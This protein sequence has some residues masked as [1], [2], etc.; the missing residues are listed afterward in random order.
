VTATDVTG[1]GWR[2]V[3]AV[4]LVIVA[5]LLAFLAVLAIWVNR[6]ALDTDNWTRTSS[7]LLQ[8]PVIRN[9]IA[10]RLTDQLFQ[11]VDAEAALRSVLPERAQAL[12]APA[13]NALRNQV[14]K[15][16]RKALA[17]PNVQALWADANRSAHQQLLAVLDDGGDTVS[18]RNGVVTLD[19]R[20]L[21]DRLQQEVGIGGRL[22]KVLPASA[23]QITLMRSDELRTAQ[24]G[25]RVLRPLPIFLIV[26]SLALFGAALLVAP[27]WRRR[28]LRAYGVGFVLA[29]L[30]AL[31]ARSVAGGDFVD[32]VA[33]TAAGEPAAAEVWSIATAM[34]V[35]IAVA[36]VCYGVVMI[37]G[38][39]L[40]GPTRWAV[41]ARRTVVPFWREP[42]FAY[43]A[44]ALI[45]AALVWWAPTPAWRNGPMLLILVAL[46]IAGTEALRR[47]MT[48]E[49]PGATRAE[50]A[51][52]RRER[53][54]RLTDATRRG[55]GTLRDSATR[56]AQ[57]ASG[58]VGAART[59]TVTRYGTSADDRLEQLER[60]AQLRAA[61]VLDEQELRAEKARILGATGENDKT[62]HIV[63]T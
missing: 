22:R 46:L 45:I 38:A 50:A 52:R 12:A 30:G 25:L 3:L 49:F 9:Q 4:V 19:V 39:W 60:L 41:A 33:K 7:E 6:Q 43:S 51:L 48:R 55:G 36:T 11:S 13:A 58:A 1:R 53:W 16:A 26:G 29:G 63:E 31:L 28:A 32:S 54:D 15:T 34:L 40:A 14:N 44:L 8:Q 61:G 17:R 57:S 27:G 37:A 62:E 35:D 21:L 47:Q 42:L 18:T 20:R 24:T 56:A 59:A 5:S 10:D 2:R 23:S